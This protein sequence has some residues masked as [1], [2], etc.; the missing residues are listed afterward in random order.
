MI[1]DIIEVDSRLR[2]D[3]RIAL[4]TMEYSSKI[5]EIL[6]EIKKNQERCPHF[7][8]IYNWTMVDDTCPYCGKKLTKESK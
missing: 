1:D 4:S 5:P 3:L 6:Q 7:S 2:N 8:V